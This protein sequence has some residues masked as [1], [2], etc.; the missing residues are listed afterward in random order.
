MAPLA[1]LTLDVLPP[2]AWEKLPND[3]FLPDNP[4]EGNLQ[5]TLAICSFDTF[6]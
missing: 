3:F 2:I 6:F 4:V 1:T 5:P